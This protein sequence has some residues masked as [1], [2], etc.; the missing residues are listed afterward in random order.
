MAE[1]L[2]H[3]FA[4][5]LNKDLATS[6]V[7][8]DSYID[9]NNIR[10]VTQE[11][12]SSGILMNILGNELSF[13][14]PNIQ[15]GYKAY[16]PSGNGKAKYLLKIGTSNYNFTINFKDPIR[17][18]VKAALG[19]ANP[20]DY[21]CFVNG[22]EITF[23]DGAKIVALTVVDAFGTDA[24]RIYVP[25][26]T[27]ALKIIGWTT[28]RDTIILFTCPTSADGSG[29]IWTVTYDPVLKTTTGPVLKYLQALNFHSKHP[30]EALGRYEVADV[31]RVYWT[32]NY[33]APRNFN[34]AS[35]YPQDTDID[36][37]SLSNNTTL[38]IP[39]ISK[40]TTGGSLLT[41]SYQYTYRL[42]KTN[43]TYSTVAP[44]S[45]LI[46]IVFSDETSSA[47]QNYEGSEK[48]TVTG[49]AVTYNIVN[50]DNSYNTIEHIFL[51]K[52]NYNDLPK[53]FIFK[54][55]TAV[56]GNIEVVH[57]KNTDSTYIPL[58]LEELTVT[59]K[60]DFQRA[61]T[62][63]TK[64]NLLFFGNTKSESFKIDYDARAY[65]F[66]PSFY[67]V[68]AAKI[69]DASRQYAPYGDITLSSTAPLY[70]NVP[71]D[72][73]AI[74]PFNHSTNLADIPYVYQKDGS[75]EG[76]EGPNIKYY[77]TTV[78][79]VVDNATDTLKT[80]PPF[81]TADRTGSVSY[82]LD[83]PG[84][85]YPQ[86]NFFS[87]IKSPYYS[88][89]YT[90]YARGEIYRFGITFYDK[91]G[92]QSYVNWIGDIRMPGHGTIPMGGVQ[93]PFRK[94]Y[95]T[96]IGIKFVV[97]IP[98][99]I[100]KICSGYSIVRVERKE[101]D[102]TTLGTGVLGTVVESRINDDTSTFWNVSHTTN[103]EDETR[104]MA[105]IKTLDGPAF[106]FETFAYKPGDYLD[107]I[108]INTTAPGT[109]GL[110]FK[111]YTRWQ[112]YA[113]SYTMN[114]TPG[115]PM[116]YNAKI[117]KY[118]LVQP[119][120]TVAADPT[121]GLYRQFTNMGDRGVTDRIGSN[122][123]HNQD[124]S[125]AGGLTALIT[126][127]TD[128]NTYDPI[129]SEL[130]GDTQRMCFVNY[131]R[132][133]ASQYGGNTYSARS[134]NIYISCNH[135]FP[136][137]SSSSLNFDVFN[138]FGGDTYVN[139][140]DHTK[141]DKNYKDD[142]GYEV[143][144][145]GRGEFDRSRSRFARVY[146]AE[147]PVNTDLRHG[148]HF[149]KDQDDIPSW[150]YGDFKYNQVYSQQNNTKVAI[151]P[152]FIDTTQEEFDNRI[153]Y[154]KPK[155][156][157]EQTDNW[158]FIDGYK[159]IESS[160]GP[161]NK[162]EVLNDNLF[163]FQDKAVANILVNPLSVIQDNNASN[164][165]LGKAAGVI[166]KHIYLST[167]IGTKHQWS[168]VKSDKSIYWFDILGKRLCKLEG[169]QILEMS[170]AKGLISYFQQNL[171]GQVNNVIHNNS[172]GYLI[173]DTPT[174]QYGIIAGYDYR[175]KEIVYTFLDSSG[176]FTL[177]FNEITNNFNS[178]YSF[179][180]NMYIYTKDKFISTDP[181]NL[182][183][184]YLHNT[185]GTYSKFYDVSYPSD[186][187][188]ITNKFPAN[189]KVYDNLELFSEITNSV[190]T[191]DDNSSFDIVEC[192]T[193]YQ[194][195]GA[196]NLT[197]GDTIKRRERSWKL[198]VPRETGITNTPFQARLRDKYLITKLTFNNTG[199][200]RRLL[201]HWIKVLFRASIS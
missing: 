122:P 43:G 3:G 91:A 175:N 54:E 8:A 10:I 98:D 87:N 70:Q 103:G 37:I 184:A 39:I 51:F 156:N 82:Y 149:N 38:N 74:N 174:Y 171:K 58:T 86:N 2:I 76:G 67:G 137:D 176:K 45:N 53:I 198:F 81:Y 141:Y 201:L 55:E 133:V 146:L 11:G 139:Y 136:I 24:T 60:N 159:D 21:F 61:K 183:K 189:T 27:S 129:G 115:V 31:Q 30:I 140:Y 181:L 84:Q 196:V 200:K 105:R 128:Y 97:S 109:P 29:Q 100:K 124:Y 57:D 132:Q 151:T 127:D 5:G 178:F 46:N 16:S 116:V 147:S 88:S 168:V 64:D 195:T 73:D 190:T 92:R 110:L 173:G 161:I 9:A 148:H 120:G 126:L 107:T 26:I 166:Q 40:I 19:F 185:D 15:K 59:T 35:E 106:H 125:A 191:E 99:S 47:F 28:I 193:K 177:S 62:I 18:Q 34:I 163:A 131:K 85:T 63:T 167:E 111:D 69:V 157:G 145:D 153:W 123:E 130:Y 121:K 52:E 169:P 49:K 199:N 154:S 20:A 150:L 66:S 90:G 114:T 101:E 6:L 144:D 75:T 1:E 96:Q 89:I 170:D 23:L 72:H 186:I 33:N 180:P 104:P 165:V 36:L 194:Q 113:K 14:I 158:T 172:Q 79:G 78:D 4:G 77:F 42:K 134:N 143:N 118:A 48:G 22:N 135:F 44:L 93:S 71:K 50:Y 160:Y 179:K 138:V 112:F 142:T 102:K 41:G 192:K 162:L 155:I 108:A 80:S 164:L 13:T 188:I 17:P 25:P 7:Q 197:V 83:V 152:P 65:R 117:L 119:A 182:N 32:D 95:A 187:T 68:P 12:Q 56:L 94:S